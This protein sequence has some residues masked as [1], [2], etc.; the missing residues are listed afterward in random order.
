MDDS[1]E[2]E[3]EESF[4]IEDEKDAY[5]VS[6]PVLTVRH[7][8]TST[9]KSLVTTTDFLRFTYTR[10][11]GS[12]DTVSY[13]TLITQHTLLALDDVPLRN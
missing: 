13:K 1:D 10:A 8:K 3:I 4:S 12:S 11:D 2:W 5:T 6:V 7:P 9:V